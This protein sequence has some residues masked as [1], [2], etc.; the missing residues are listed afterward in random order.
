[1]FIGHLRKS[2]FLG[3]I[4]ITM[5]SIAHAITGAFIADTLP[6]PWLFIPLALASHF[7]LDHVHHYDAGTGLHEGKRKLYVAAVFAFLDLVGAAVLLALIW[8]QT[9]THFT[10]Q[11]WLAAF[12][13][14]LPDI[15][16]STELFFHR[17]LKILQPL[18]SFH[19]YIHRSTKNPFWGIL[20]QV[21]LVV[22]IYA[23]VITNW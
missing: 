18:Y 3:I 14:I 22:F 5:L 15:L 21:I 10:W 20:T 4:P 13:A 23:L 8:R 11:I 12:V 19:E 17:P 6:S 2:L 9:P 16:E 1:M 7:I